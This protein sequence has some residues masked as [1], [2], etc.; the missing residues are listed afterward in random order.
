M[1]PCEWK[2]KGVGN[3]IILER[4]D[5]LSEILVPVCCSFQFLPLDTCSMLALARLRAGET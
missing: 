2:E 5:D 1:G 4:L 3:G